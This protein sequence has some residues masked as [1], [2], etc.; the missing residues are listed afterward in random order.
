MADAVSLYLPRNSL[1]H[2]L[3]PLT[4]LSLVGVILVGG[5]FLPGSW[6]NYALLVVVLFPLA[7][8][9]RLFRAWGNA[10]WRVA[11]PFAVSVFLIQGF[12]WPHGTPLV[13]FGP[14]SLK[15][16]G[17]FFAIAST[18][19]ILVVIGSFLWF[20]FTTRPDILMIS[21]AQRGLPASLAYL[22]VATIQIVPRFQAR[23]VSIIDAQR[24]RGLETSGNL[25]QRGRAVLPLVIPL[26]LSSLTDVEERA[27]AIEARAF[28]HPV[29]KTSLVE[30]EE[31]DWEPAARWGIGIVALLCLILSLYIRLKP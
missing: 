21:L 23:A 28:N 29:P 18:G 19:R 15:R 2:R 1:I 13:G 10:T 6:T 11:L 26:I 31:A 27:L 16:E 20:A 7:L 4:K 30:I 12:L 9:A 24:A 17:L 25:I 3:H 5:L 8:A 14:I 22:I